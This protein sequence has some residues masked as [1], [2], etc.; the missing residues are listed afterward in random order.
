[1][2]LGCLPYTVQDL[3]FSC[4]TLRK[5]GPA[6]VFMQEHRTRCIPSRSKAH[7]HVDVFACYCLHTVFFMYVD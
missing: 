4:M 5:I 6:T 7:W 1:M 3:G 2:S